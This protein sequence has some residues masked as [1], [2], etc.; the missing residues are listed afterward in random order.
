M[1]VGRGTAVVLL[2]WSVVA[3]ACGGGGWWGLDQLRMSK[4]P[5]RVFRR[6]EPELRDYVARLTAGQVPA[7]VGREP[8]EYCMP[9][10]LIAHGATRAFWRGDRVVIQFFVG[11]ADPVPQLEYSPGGFDPREI[12]Y[13]RG[14]HYFVWV[15]LARDWA[16][17]Y[18]DS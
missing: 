17:C 7:A 2:G 5:E 3:I 8:D 12:E 1:K 9:Q 14:G 10:F 4:N 11:P 15:P 16:A 18:W 13:R 6:Y